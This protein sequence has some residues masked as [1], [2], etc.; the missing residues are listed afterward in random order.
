MMSQPLE[1]SQSSSDYFGEEDTQYLKA[2][3]TLALPGD[4]PETEKAQANDPED[5]CDDDVIEESPPPPAQ[6]RPKRRHSDLEPEQIQDE[7]IYGASKF[8]QFGEYMRRKRAKLQIQ[9]QALENKSNVNQAKNFGIFQGI[10]IYVRQQS[11][12]NLD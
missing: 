1:N 5:V 11:I 12:L 10:A 8:G 2:L 3:E 6:P 7:D 9:N 4:K